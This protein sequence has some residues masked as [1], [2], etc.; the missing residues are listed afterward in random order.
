MNYLKPTFK[1]LPINSLEKTSHLLIEAGEEC[2]SFVYYSKHPLRIEAVLI[3]NFENNGSDV[4]MAKE[5]SQFFMQESLPGFVYC[6]ICYNNKESILQPSL[7]YKQNLLPSTLDALYGINTSASC[8]AESIA[9]M[10]AHV[11]YRVDKRIEKELKQRF[12]MA[13]TQHVLALQI[14]AFIKKQDLFYCI[15]YQRSIKVI[16]IK[17]QIVQLVQFF[18]YSTPADTAYHL[19][20][21]CTQHGIT[22]Q[23]ITLMLSGFIDRKSNLYDELYRYFLNIEMDV[24]DAEVEITEAVSQY[25]LHFFFF[26]FSLAKCVS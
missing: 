18:E 9:G 4:E 10:D 20:N 3:Y 5:L 23:E 16:L 26:F 24:P 8:Y 15:V 7:F 1:I 19:L 17:D 14:P 2:I 21:V 25:P 12:P 22:P 6:N 13:V 11:T